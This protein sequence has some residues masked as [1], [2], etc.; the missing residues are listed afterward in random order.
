METC[1]EGQWNNLAFEV[2]MLIEVGGDSW[3]D[4]F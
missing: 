2:E 3:K 1:L 4:T